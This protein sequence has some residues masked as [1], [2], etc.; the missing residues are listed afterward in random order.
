MHRDGRT[1]SG[2][3]TVA[4]ESGFQ[5][6]V[7]RTVA[8]ARLA[9]L[10]PAWPGLAPPADP[11]TV[12]PPDPATANA[13]PDDRAARGQGVRRRR[14]R[15]GDRRLLPHGPLDGRAAPTR[16]ASPSPAR[17]PTSA[18]PA[19]PGG[20]AATAWPGRRPVGWPT[21]T[22]PSSAPGPRPRRNAGV[23][24]VEIPPARY[25]VVLEPTAVADILEAFS[26]YGFNAKAVAERRSFV[27]VGEAQFDPA[28]T[29]STTRRRRGRRST[30]RARRAS[31]S[32]SSTAGTTVALTHDR[33]TAADAGATSTGHG[34]GLGVVR[35][36]RPPPHAARA[37]TRRRRRPPRSTGR[38]ST[39]PPPSWSPGS[40]GGSWS[41][42]SG[43]PA[44]STPA[45]SP[46]PG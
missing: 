19:S 45:R 34:V 7:E 31:A 30:P 1:I 15:P 33:R 27:R 11:A 25:E 29:S 2:S 35:R 18:W 5:A 37:A 28:V 23:D 44:C 10:D 9:P 14:R 41:P 4:D 36:R 40:S 42:T 22:A 6:L 26:M 8:A 12:A 39:P 43:T 13:S 3:S 21:S 20:R 16:P 38:S 46:S 24:A 17:A 32:C